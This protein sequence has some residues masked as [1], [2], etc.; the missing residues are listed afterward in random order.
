MNP[1]ASV[2]QLISE[3]LDPK[4]PKGSGPLTLVPLFG[5]VTAKEYAVGA[6]AFAD[7]T[8]TITE[9]DH[10]GDVTHLEAHNTGSLPVLLIDGEHLEGAK[11][12]R[13]LNAT[14]LVGANRTSTLPVACVEQGRWHYEDEHED[15]AGKFSL[16]AD[17]AYSDL[18]SKNASVRAANV[19]HSASREVDQSQVWDEVGKLHDR[20]GPV[21]ATGA[22]RDSFDHRRIELDAIKEALMQPEVGQTGV[23][24]CI[25]GRPVALDAFDSPETLS[26]LWP[27]L[28]SGYALDAV[29]NPADKVEETAVAGFLSRA[30]QA[31]STSHE[32]LGV[33]MDVVLTAP[34]VVGN[35]LT[36]EEGV[37]HLAL[38]ARNVAGDAPNEYRAQSIDRPS[39]RR[40]RLTGSTGFLLEE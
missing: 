22:I 12:N 38:F 11:Q 40:A 39:H 36:W 13:I 31:E 26:K 20:L 21:S 37:V 19:R 7:G 3:G 16:S 34:D 33:G 28:L 5:G 32:G 6:D 1:I 24:A 25:G 4:E 30:A 29:G 2:V 35:A 9:V 23:I 14:A 27:R 8:L 10:D 17:I 18:R 15:G